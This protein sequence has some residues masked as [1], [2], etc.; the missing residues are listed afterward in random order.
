[1][2]AIATE[3]TASILNTQ[4]LTTS[5]K[6]AIHKI[7]KDQTNNNRSIKCTYRE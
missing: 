1:M 3:K 4:K 2:E 6:S 5:W 7:I